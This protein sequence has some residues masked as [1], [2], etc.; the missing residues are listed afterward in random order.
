MSQ[1]TVSIEQQ[2]HEAG[3]ARVDMKLE[4]SL[5]PVSDVDRAKEFYTRLGWRFDSDDAMGSDFRIV[6]LIL[7]CYKVDTFRPEICSIRVDR[8]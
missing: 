6:Q 5:I 1:T 8:C 2:K 3:A 4:V 7:L